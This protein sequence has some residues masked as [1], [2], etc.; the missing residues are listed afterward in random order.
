MEPTWID[1][2]F[3]VFQSWVGVSFRIVDRS[4]LWHLRG[5]GMSRADWVITQKVGQAK[6]TCRLTSVSPAKRA[7]E[8][9]KM[10]YSAF[11]LTGQDEAEFSN[12]N[13]AVAKTC[14]WIIKIIYVFF[15][16]TPK[17]NNIPLIQMIFMTGYL[18]KFRV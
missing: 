14:H 18:S 10:S 2:S 4:G 13:Y 17:P 5:G 12:M 7:G 16:P 6:T 9:R 8:R 11:C 15:I 1:Y 3:I